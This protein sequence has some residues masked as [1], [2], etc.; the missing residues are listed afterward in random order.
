MMPFPTRLYQVGHKQLYHK[1]P[2][3]ERPVHFIHENDMEA[4]SS[5]IRLDAKWLHRNSDLRNIAK[6]WYIDRCLLHDVGKVFMESRAYF[7]VDQV[8]MCLG[9][10][11]PGHYAF[12]RSGWVAGFIPAQQADTNVVMLVGLYS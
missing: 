12:F 11:S 7:N 10:Q 1:G 4:F 5:P 3:V 9:A 6:R 2:G 8:A